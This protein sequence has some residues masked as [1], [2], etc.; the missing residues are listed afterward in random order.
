MRTHDRPPN[1]TLR[2]IGN[3]LTAVDA[4]TGDECL[5]AIGVNERLGAVEELLWKECRRT[6]E[7]FPLDGELTV[8]QGAG[9]ARDLYKTGLGALLKL[10]GYENGG[11]LEEIQRFFGERIP[12]DVD[13]DAATPPIIDVVTDHGVHL[14]IETMP[15]FGSIADADV[16]DSEAPLHAIGRVA[17]AYRAVIR[18]AR[19]GNRGSRATGTAVREQRRISVRFFQHA[20]L[21]GMYIETRRLAELQGTGALSVDIVFPPRRFRPSPTWPELELAK[22]IAGTPLEGTGT[23]A[24]SRPTVC[25]F[26]CHLYHKNDESLLEMRPPWA[27]RA[28]EY[29]LDQLRSARGQ[30]HDSFAAP[31][32]VFLNTCRSGVAVSST[33]TSAA[34]VLTYFDPTCLIGTIADLPDRTAAMFSGYFYDALTRGYSAGAALRSARLRLLGD[35]A[36]NPYGLLYTTYYG[37]DVSMPTSADRVGRVV[38]DEVSAMSDGQP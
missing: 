30:L 1:V 2:L 22:C 21:A 13:P 35:P 6:R 33:R 37:E 4:A 36:K 31:T 10:V 7:R 9:V 16:L 17:P 34:E 20:R 38:P 32:I 27:L 19:A 29:S 26:S 28:Q 5:L 12:V 8:R 25:H 11:R 14:P 24:R 3:T 18:R 15:L 23:P